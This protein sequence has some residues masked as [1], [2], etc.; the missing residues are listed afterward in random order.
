MLNC[1]H[2]VIYFFRRGYFWWPKKDFKVFPR[3]NGDMICTQCR[4]ASILAVA[5][6]TAIPVGLVAFFAWAFT[7]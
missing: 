5:A 4:A 7:R 2:G 1:A 6:G 3:Q